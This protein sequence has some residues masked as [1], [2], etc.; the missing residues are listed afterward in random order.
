MIGPMP[1]DERDCFNNTNDTRTDALTRPRCTRVND[2][3]MRRVVRTRNER[4]PAGADDRD[5]AL[6]AA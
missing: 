4:L 2:Y 5:R 6:G 3:Q 1:L